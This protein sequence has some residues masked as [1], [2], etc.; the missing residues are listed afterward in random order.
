MPRLE[1]GKNTRLQ[2]I[3]IDLVD[4]K[5]IQKLIQRH[6]RRALTALFTAA[7]IKK[8]GPKN[9][10]RLARLFA[11][12]EAFFKAAG[13]AWLGLENFLK[14]EVHCSSEDHFRVESSKYKVSPKDN[15]FADGQFFE[16]GNWVGA[17]VLIW[18]SKI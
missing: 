12:K 6:P 5:R 1:A 15:V 18:G 9:I 17:Q 14:I 3:G 11:A 16:C 10:R 4:K 8:T 2:G 7:E 13:G